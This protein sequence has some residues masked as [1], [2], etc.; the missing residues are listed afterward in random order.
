MPALRQRSFFF[1]FPKIGD[2]EKLVRALF[3]VARDNL[4]AVIFIDEID[5]LLT[6][7]SEQEHE[8]SRRI[9]TEFLVQ[10]VRAPVDADAALA[11]APCCTYLTGHLS[12]ILFLFIPP[13]PK[14]GRRYDKHGRA[15]AH[16]RRDQQAAGAGRGGPATASKAALH[17]PARLQC[18]L[19]GRFSSLKLRSCFSPLI[20]CRR[21]VP[22]PSRAPTARRQPAQGPKPEPDRRGPQHH[23]QAVRGLLW[24]GHVLRVQGAPCPR[25]SLGLSAAPESLSVAPL[26]SLSLTPTPP[27]EAALGPVRDIHDIASIAADNVREIRMEDFDKALRGVRPSVS[28]KEIEGYIAWD[29]DFGSHVG[30]RS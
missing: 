18:V 9:K 20:Q 8:S 28:E 1:A 17:S 6:Q 12:T 11:A 13:F 7:R 2:G 24:L 22:A 23:L 30:D 21:L 10:L 29:N 27:Q 14:K 4:P 16:C 25:D 26:P 15:L 3:A 19:Q 5:S